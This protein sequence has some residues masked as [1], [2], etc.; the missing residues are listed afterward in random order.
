MVES[1]TDAAALEILLDAFQRTLDAHRASFDKIVT[2]AFRS[3][4]SY[5]KL[6]QES[7]R[8]LKKVDANAQKRRQQSAQWSTTI[9]ATK[10][11]ETE[12]AATAVAQVGE[13]EQRVKQNAEETLNV[14]APNMKTG[15]EDL[16][17]SC[18]NARNGIAQVT[19]ATGH[20]LKTYTASDL[21]C[22]E[23]TQEDKNQTADAERKDLISGLK[24][25]IEENIKRVSSLSFQYIYMALLRLI[26][27]F[28]MHVIVQ[29]IKLYFV[30]I[31][32]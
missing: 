31:S 16:L 1:D 22:K 6:F 11:E 21:R 2:I 15:F 29:L 3:A 27:I 10:K 14:I 30:S 25:K 23:V 17:K 32:N 4:E 28:S 20:L 5:E 26:L 18:E 8:Y 12:K 7:M 19:E 9:V 24:E 13:A